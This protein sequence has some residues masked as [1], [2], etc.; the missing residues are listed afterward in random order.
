MDLASIAPSSG[1]QGVAADRAYRNADFLSI[2]LSEITH[3]DPMKPQE[4]SKLVEGMQA[5][6][7]L[8]NS[9]FRKFRED[10]QWAGD[11]VDKNVI[12][13]QANLSKEELAKVRELG[14]DPDV[15]FATAAGRITSYRVVNDSVWVQVNG[16]DYPIDN[17]QNI[18]ASERDPR[19][20]AEMA[21]GLLGAAC[22]YV[23]PITRTLKNGRITD[24]KWNANGDFAV[25]VNQQE[26]P[27][28][29]IRRLGLAG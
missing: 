18:T 20:V 16:K 3:Q 8:A 25:I 28:A 14:I 7:E 23:D 10:I 21:A 27:F 17:V 15:G 22:D 13:G 4:T 12:V 11:L 9:R 2:M 19:A 29:N 1:T 5:L 6:Q 24:L 26:V